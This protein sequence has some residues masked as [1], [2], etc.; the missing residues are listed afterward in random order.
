MTSVYVEDQDLAIAWGRALEAATQPVV[1]DLLPLVVSI[2]GFSTAGD[3]T[4]DPTI[5]ASLDRALRLQG[6][7]SIE[8]V[9]NTIFPRSLWNPT[10]PRSQLFS[11]Y[12]AILPKLHRAS[13]KNRHGL[14][15]ERMLSGGP[16]GSE[17]QLDFAI[18]AYTARRH[19]RRSILQV[20]I[21]QPNRDHS[22]AAMRGFPCL[23]HITFAPASDGLSLNA[24]YATQYLVERAYG[25]YLGLCRL[26]Q[27]VAHELDTKLIRVTCFTGIAELAT[28]K[29]AVANVL[30]DVRSVIQARQRGQAP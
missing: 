30:G 1:R 5:R 22:K 2:T 20:S 29:A 6:K 23:Q 9:A 15:F 28:P 10:A 27:F 26:G 7:Q 4:E 17:N 16:P 3:V 8:T 19:V 24:F 18:S 25:N 13:P 21:F 11:R 12:R 14:Y